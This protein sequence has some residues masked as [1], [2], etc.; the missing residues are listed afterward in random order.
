MGPQEG[1][2][3]GRALCWREPLAKAETMGGFRRV[4]RGSERL[5]QVGRA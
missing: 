5:L 1:R 4:W 3:A 2:E